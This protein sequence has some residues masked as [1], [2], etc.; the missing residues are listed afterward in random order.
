MQ[1]FITAT[2][3]ARC[4]HR[5]L[6]F[7]IN[8]STIPNVVF[9][10][11]G[12]TNPAHS[13]RI[14]LIRAGVE[15]NP[16]PPRK[17]DSSPPCEFCEVTIRS[18]VSRFVCAAPGCDTACHL[19][20]ECS[21]IS[22]AL[23]WTKKWFCTQHRPLASP[24]RPSLPPPQRRILSAS[25]NVLCPTCNDKLMPN[26]I[27]C[28]SC[29][30]FHHQKCT[31]LPHRYAIKKA[32]PTWKCDSCVS[33]L[34]N[35]TSPTTSSP[36]ISS[37]GQP[38]SSPAISTPSQSTP[39]PTNSSTDQPTSSPAS[40][41]PGQP[42]TTQDSSGSLSSLPLPQCLNCKKTVHSSYLTCVVCK[43]ASHQHEKCS[44]LA[45]RGAQEKAKTNQDWECK[46]CRI[47]RRPP[48]QPPET[49]DATSQKSEPKSR[50]LKQPLR[51]LQWNAEGLNTKTSELN[52]FLDEYKIDIAV[53][54]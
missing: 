6:N 4:P 15:T 37:P 30:K 50:T 39:S 26:P 21:L 42:A 20:P 31:G 45:T 11:I 14:L 12:G 17:S 47:K 54:Q 8:Q 16:G 13:L 53:I 18:G 32:R 5:A 24:D 35:P 10:S 33:H 23:Q 49:Q 27:Q 44:G 48:D 40:S 7:N 25:S 43:R 51:I 2:N 52:F 34:A 29:R 22:R 46:Y 41:P 1:N 28:I 19:K 36:V 3:N 38:I 9:W